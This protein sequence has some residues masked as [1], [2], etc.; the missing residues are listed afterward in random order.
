MSVPT[1]QPPRAERKAVNFV[2]LFVWLFRL[3]VGGTF[4]I[5]GVTKLVDLWGTVFKIEDYFTVWQ[6]EVPRTVVL[7]GAMALS[8]FEFISGLLVLTGCYRR[9]LTWLV[10]LLMAAMLVLTAYIWYADP[11]SD[12]G[13]FGDFIILSNGA[14]FAKNIVLMAMIIYLILYNRRCASLFKAPIQW[15]VVT[16]V[17]FYSIAISLVGYNIQP[18]L[19]FRPYPVG[20]P[21]LGDESS[22]GGDVQF[23]YSRDGVEKVFGSDELPDEDAGWAYVRRIEPEADDSKTL[24]AYDPVTG[25]DVTFDYLEGADSLLILV[26]PEPS[27]ADLSNTY[28]INELSDAISRDGSSMVALLAT[29]QRGIERW[30]DH[31][32]A[33]Y[34]CLQVEDT[35]LKQLS[36]GVMSMVW[37]TGDTV[38]WKRT[39]S[40]ITM[41]DVDRI[42][43][44][45]ASMSSLAIDGPKEFMR[46]TVVFGGFLVVLFLLQTIIINTWQLIKKKRTSSGKQPANAQ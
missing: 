18:L 15:I 31:S 27:R 43:S 45:K 41:D 11:V 7:I 4:I 2:G 17:V 1:E 28:L 44:G 25:E 24:T 34:P 21:L 16:A 23:V 42:V 5:S 39:V 9:V 32:M 33:S 30:V 26:L 6:W 29:S 46:L 10:G 13:C 35:S 8:T 37:V 3:I 14:T 12:C 38:R 20:A 36:R 19:D 22:D 40:S